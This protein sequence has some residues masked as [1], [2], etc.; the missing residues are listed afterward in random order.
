MNSGVHSNWSRFSKL[1]DNFYYK[2]VMQG[3]PNITEYY[4][5]VY[6][7]R[8]DLTD[9][10]NKEHVMF[11]GDSFT[12]GHGVDSKSTITHFLN[13]EHLPANKM[14]INLG[15][16]GTSPEH[17][18]LVLNKWLNEPYIDNMK[19]IVFGLSSAMRTTQWFNTEY[20]DF[21]YEKKSLYNSISVQL[22]MLPSQVNFS[23]YSNKLNSVHKHR[24][25]VFY[26]NFCDPIYC[27]QEYEKIL[28]ELKYIS[29]YAKADVL[30]WQISGLTMDD[31]FDRPDIRELHKIYN[32]INSDLNKRGTRFNLLGNNHHVPIWSKEFKLQDGHYNK[33]GNRLVAE[34]MYNTDLK[35]L[36]S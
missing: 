9:F 17:S 22:N 16:P 8:T 27:L 35:R 10:E 33:K 1:S 28:M 12:F 2:T 30:I 31:L 4:D 14:C 34:Y 5:S 7:T 6:P 11:F 26:E 13:K 19:T 36:L 15:F 32:S 3:D 20:E 18:M 21:G 24:H 25:K 23:K 29:S